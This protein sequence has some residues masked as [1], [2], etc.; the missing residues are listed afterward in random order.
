[1]KSFNNIL[2][3]IDFSECSEKVFPQALEMVKKFDGRLHLLF[4]VTDLSYLTTI[5]MEGIFNT[6]M[7]TNGLGE[8][9][10]IR[11]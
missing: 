4:V 6:P 3:P 5:D 7:T 10:D 2:F 8:A 9:R 1:M 11:A